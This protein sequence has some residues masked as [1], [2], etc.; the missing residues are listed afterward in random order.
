MLIYLYLNDCNLLTIYIHVLSAEFGAPS[1]RTFDVY[2]KCE[3]L[4]SSS[5]NGGEGG[6]KPLFTKYS[7]IDTPTLTNRIACMFIYRGVHLIA[8]VM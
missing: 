1:N 3:F 2:L 7:G 5:W 4:D 6:S 8:L